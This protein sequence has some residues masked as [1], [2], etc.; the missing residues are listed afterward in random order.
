MMIRLLLLA[1]LLLPSLA[2]AEIGPQ[3]TVSPA[4]K[5]WIMCNGQTATGPCTRKGEEI[6]LKDGRAYTWQFLA[7]TSTATTFSC[8]AFS[9]SSGFN[10]SLRAPLS[11]V[12][13]TDTVLSIHFD[14]LLVSLWF[15]CTTLTGGTVT[16]T[17]HAEPLT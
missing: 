10:A 11:G 17:A 3:Q 13:L 1:S 15:E 5:A 12:I 6:V 16:I 2:W 4:Q 8:Q 14:G 7:E 9:A